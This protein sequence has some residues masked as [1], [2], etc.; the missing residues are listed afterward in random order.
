MGVEE[1]SFGKTNVE[2]EKNVDTYSEDVAKVIVDCG[3]CDEPLADVTNL[4]VEGVRTC[5]DDKMVDDDDDTSTID[6][7]CVDEG[8]RDG[9]SDD[10][11]DDKTGCTD[12]VIKTGLDVGELVDGTKIDV[13]LEGID[14]GDS[15]D[16]A[17]PVG[18]IKTNVLLDSI[19][20]DG[21][22]DGDAL[23]TDD[24]EDVNAKGKVVDSINEEVVVLGMADV[25]GTTKL[26]VSTFVEDKEETFCVVLG[27]ESIVVVV[28][29]DSVADINDP[30]LRLGQTDCDVPLN[31][32]KVVVVVEEIE[33]VA[34]KIELVEKV[35]LVVIPV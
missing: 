30:V 21:N 1:L 35:E 11:V 12:E 17:E 26:A 8:G 9:N 19:D 14:D 2:D 18:D 3:D 32:V 27:A 15:D 20:D 24:S 10:D 5:S 13:I 16:E 4:D 25:A 29:D 33:F 28:E 7:V 31:T 23:N 6:R 34:E 22:A